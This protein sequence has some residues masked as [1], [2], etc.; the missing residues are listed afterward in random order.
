[1]H[2][3]SLYSVYSLFVKMYFS[4]YLVS[5]RLVFIY[6]VYLFTCYFLSPDRLMTK[7]L[8]SLASWHLSWTS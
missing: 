3:F 2:S 4:I 5:R 1:M 7:S 8:R 6:V